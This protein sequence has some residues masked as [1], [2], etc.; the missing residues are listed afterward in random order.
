MAENNFDA[1]PVRARLKPGI[2]PGLGE[3][4]AQNR[5]Q[6]PADHSKK[7]RDRI[8]MKKGKEQ[9]DCSGDDT[10]RRYPCR[11]ISVIIVFFQSGTPPSLFCLNI[12]NY[13][14]FFSLLPPFLKTFTKT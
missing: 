8:H 7:V 1:K 5:P 4:P 2:L 6:N 11:Y 13:T 10:K 12:L 9:E 3:D 14:L